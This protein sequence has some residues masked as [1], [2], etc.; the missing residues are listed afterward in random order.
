[1]VLDAAPTG[2]A[3]SDRQQLGRCRDKV[4]FTLGVVNVLVIA[5]AAGGHPGFLTYY[6]TI[7]F[8][9]LLGIRWWYYTKK[10]CQAPPRLPA[11]FAT[12]TRDERG[13]W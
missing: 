7:K 8:P 3:C 1:M 12:T 6:Y 2:L 11:C 4:F 9:L 5:Y 10:V 13:P